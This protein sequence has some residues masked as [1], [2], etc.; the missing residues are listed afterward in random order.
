MVVLANILSSIKN[1]ERAGKYEV[2]VRPISSVVK[3]ILGI[4]KE[5]NYINDVEF[6]DNRKGG[7]AKIKLT[8]KINDIGEV[9]PNFY[10]GVRNLR[11]FE[12]RYLPAEGF[13]NLI[14]TTP[15]GVI[16]NTKARELNTGGQLLAYV[17]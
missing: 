15:K 3:K 14:L 1:A 2:T 13:G 7:E 11:K 12:K 6:T 4:L 9:T 8:G 5:L 17:Y 10:V 16:T